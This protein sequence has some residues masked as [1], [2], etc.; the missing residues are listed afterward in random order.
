MIHV[1]RSTVIEASADR[2]WSMLRDFGA[3]NRWH[4]AVIRSDIDRAQP[5]D[6]VGCIRSL[7]TGAG[8]ELREQ[9]LS[10]SDIEM[11]LSYCALETSIPLFNF[12][13][14]MRLVPITDVEGTFWRWEAKF[15]TRAR[16][17]D[18]MTKFVA[19]ESMARGFAAVRTQ[20]AA[21]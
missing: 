6:R 9:L 3:L 10:L 15:T 4:P 14:Q 16:D 20:M 2:V 12:F 7:R 13:A 18:A 17:T 19:D 21:T 8:R 1:I 11:S 5:Q